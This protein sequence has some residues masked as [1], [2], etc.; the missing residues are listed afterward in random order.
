MVGS[1]AVLL[2]VPWFWHGLMAQGSAAA[3]SAKETFQV[4]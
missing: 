1:V 2:H 3:A 4:N